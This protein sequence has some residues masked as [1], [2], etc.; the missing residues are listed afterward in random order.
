MLPHACRSLGDSAVLV[1]LGAARSEEL[2]L[3]AA[4]LAD[5]LAPHLGDIAS[6]VVPGYCSVLVRFDA[7]SIRPA[8]QM[9]AVR[10]ALA[11]FDSV[12]GPAEALDSRPASREHTVRV[13][14]G[15]E[16]GVDFERTAHDLGMRESRMRDMFCAPVYRVAF[17]GFLAG[18]PYLLGL[19]AALHGIERLARPRPRVPAGSVAVA[20]GQCGIYPMAT[21][22]GWRLLGRTDAVL[23]DPSRRVAT[24]FQPFDAIR[25]EPVADFQDAA[26]AT[27]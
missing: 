9:R 21:A 2:A 1:E 13:C 17:L 7:Y 22:G 19:P 26:V 5:W 15:G 25:F 4:G 23:F 18:F 6:D 16:Y 27:S 24:L 11:A 14:F 10:E 20:A 8:D 3:R 12:G